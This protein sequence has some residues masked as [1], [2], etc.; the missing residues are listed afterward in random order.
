MEH[1]AKGLPNRRP[2]IYLYI[3]IYIV[4]SARLKA[5]AISASSRLPY[6]Q[7]GQEPRRG[8]LVLEETKG[9][10]GFGAVNMRR[11]Y[12]VCSHCHSSWIWEDRLL[13]RPSVACNQ[14]AEK[15]QQGLLPDLKKRKGSAG[16]GGTLQVQARTGQKR[17]TRRPCSKHHQV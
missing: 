17:P 1:S 15:W 10:V 13:G 3:K 2:S 16:Q 7:S 14:C 12:R 9:Q 11:R 4:H 5:Q 8:R 6:G